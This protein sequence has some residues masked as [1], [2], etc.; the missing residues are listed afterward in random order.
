MA[1]VGSYARGAPQPDSD[2]DAAIF[3]LSPEKYVNDRSWLKLFG[4]VDEV[5]FEK[6]G[7]VQTVRAFL[8]SAME[9]E[10]NFSTLDWAQIPA[11]PGTCQVVLG[12]FEILYDPTGQ[13]T[14]LKHEV[15]NRSASGA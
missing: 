11:D 7:P 15:Y 3:C 8:S 10:F 1:I 5:R 14:R 12:G 2:I 6:W 13:L 9:I 4:E